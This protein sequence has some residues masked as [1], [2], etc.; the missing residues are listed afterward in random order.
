MIFH[1]ADRAMYLL[2]PV[3]ITLAATIITGLTW[4]Y[5]TIILPMLAGNNWVL[6]QMDWEKYLMKEQGENDNVRDTSDADSNVIKDD[7]G[8]STPISQITST[9]L[10]LLTPI[11]ILH[12]S[13]VSFFLVNILY[14]Y[15]YCVSTSNSGPSYDNVVRQLAGVTGFH[16]PDTEEELL[17]CKINFERKIYERVQ[18]KRDEVMNTSRSSDGTGNANPSATTV[19]ITRND[20]DEES[21]TILTA[22]TTNN[23]AAITLPKIHNWQ[24]LS[25]IE[26]G[27]CRYS[28]QPK[29]P[30]SHYD[31]VTKG[32]VLNM[33]HYCPWMFNCV[34]YFN[35][36]YFFNFLWFVSIALWYGAAICYPAFMLLGGTEYKDQLRASGVY[37]KPSKGIVVRHLASN[38][39]IPTPGERTPVALGFMMCL[40]LAAAVTG[41]CGFHL[42][43]VLSAQT[44]IEFHGNF[45]KKRNPRWNNPYSTGSW[46]KNWEMIYGTRNYW[47]RRCINEDEQP[48]RF[49]GCWNL[50]MGMMPSN[51]EPEFLPFPIVGTLVRRSHVS[52]DV[53]SVGPMHSSEGLISS[54]PEFVMISKPTDGLLVG[55]SRI[56]APSII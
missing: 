54:G 32:L 38:S 51:R 20:G 28:S 16:Y 18:R 45:R 14:N 31:H 9:L 29:P 24:L 7:G 11:G 44:T 19:S 12:T 21:Q 35:Y 30:R 4:L 46:K 1:C 25:P 10:A 17:Q 47:S 27:Y 52:Q 48:S 40:C 22:N 3:L 13:I 37:Q 39:F 42:Y 33:D 41:L 43:L 49:R 56:S 8:N 36:R 53:E 55:R 5:F 23:T 15:Y 6:T 2:G 50:L 26:W 34:G